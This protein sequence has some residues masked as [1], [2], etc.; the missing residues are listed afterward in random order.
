MPKAKPDPELVAQARELVAMGASLREAG[1]TLG[2]SA[3]TIKRWIESEPAERPASAPPPP[4]PPVAL[5]AHMK[6][7]EVTPIV[8]LD[9]S[10]PRRM[11][12]QLIGDIY[13][14]IQHNRASGDTRQMGS[15]AATVSKLSVTMRQL[16]EAAQS[17]ADGVTVSAAEV[18]RIEASLA[19]RIRAVCNRPLLCSEC[20]RELSVFWGTGLTE[21]ALNADDHDTNAI[22]KPA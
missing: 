12:E 3:P 4:P 21:A 2:V 19:E 11:V 16:N 9:T 6:P 14:M 10:D 1:H 13:S 18:A 22:A 17:A 7:P 20:S 8:P 5:P 15:L